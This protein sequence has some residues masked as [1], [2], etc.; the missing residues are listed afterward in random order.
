MGSSLG[1]AEVQA[2]DT[3]RLASDTSFRVINSKTLNNEFM[4]FEATKFVLICY[5]DNKKLTQ[6][7]SNAVINACLLF[8]VWLK[9][10]LG[11]SRRAKVYYKKTTSASWRRDYWVWE[12]WCSCLDRNYKNTVAA[13]IKTTFIYISQFN[14]ALKHDIKNNA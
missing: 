7:S 11:V 2:A 8:C 12:T 9:K 14:K 10:Y 4:L 5:N 13:H 1:S 3:L 6:W